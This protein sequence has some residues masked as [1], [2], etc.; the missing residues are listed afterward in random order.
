[1][2]ANN[3]LHTQAFESSEITRHMIG[4]LVDTTVSTVVAHNKNRRHRNDTLFDCDSL[5]LLVGSAD[6]PGP[7]ARNPKYSNPKGGSVMR[8]LLL[9]LLPSVDPE[10]LRPVGAKSSFAAGQW[11]GP[12]PY[13]RQARNP[14]ERHFRAR[15]RA[16]S[17]F[18]FTSPGMSW[19]VTMSPGCPATNNSS[20]SAGA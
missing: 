8:H 15:Y 14:Q 13:C 5:S 16:R 10:P 3:A 18:S 7:P 6:P 11:P 19:K 4:T 12:S 1:M 9:A 17:L 20:C 2:G